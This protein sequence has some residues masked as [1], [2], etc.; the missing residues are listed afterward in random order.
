MS[1]ITFKKAIRKAEFLS[2][3][4]FKTTTHSI[5]FR[6]DP[7]TDRWCRMNMERARRI[8]QAQKRNFAED[9]DMIEETRQ[10]CFFCRENVKKATPM[11]P[12]YFP[13]ERMRANSACLFPNLFPFG[14]FHAIGVL[15]EE[16]YVPLSGFS[17]KLL[18]NCFRVCLEY[19][20]FIY[21]RH[22][23]MKYC[24]INWNY[25]PPAAAS[26]IHPHL[27]ILADRRP[28]FQTSELVKA[29]KRYHQRNKGNYWLDLIKV[30][31]EESD[32][33]IGETGS[34]AWLASFTPQGNKEILAIFSEGISTLIRLSESGLNDF[35]EGLSRILRGY[36]EMG[37]KSFNMTTFSGPNDQDISEY[38]LLN[39]K[40]ISRPD[41]EPF[42]TNDDGFM[43]K[44]HYEPVVETSPEDVAERMREYL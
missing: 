23:D 41:F 12:A 22:P 8:K 11:F 17:P 24:M 26:I 2:P 18:K 40:L 43:E 3:P 29:S 42:Y 31:K 19:F 27:Q 36:H 33:W 1:K 30:E 32:R 25:L 9:A 44:F 20:K 14:E 13:A 10:K 16:H 37:V 15:S 21:D 39:A 7:L 4:D 28:T 6:K 5:E 38:Y 34:V 35:C